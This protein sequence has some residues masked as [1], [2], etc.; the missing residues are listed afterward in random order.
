MSRR[1]RAA[2]LENIAGGFKMGGRDGCVALRPKW[3]QLK[4]EARDEACTALRGG[5]LLVLVW[6][7]CTGGSGVVRRSRAPCALQD[8]E[9]F[10]RWHAYRGDQRARQ[11]P[12][13]VVADRSGAQERRQHQTT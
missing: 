2:G 10:T 1:S 12:D 6:G 7:G 4:R 5:R 11:R 13:R 9:D 8:G 3:G